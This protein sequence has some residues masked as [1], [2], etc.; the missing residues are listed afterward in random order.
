MHTPF[1]RRPGAA[2]ATR[3]FIA[4]TVIGLLAPAGDAWAQRPPAR[5]VET[6]AV[7]DA[8]RLEAPENIAIDSAGNIFV[9]LVLT[10]EIRRITPDGAQS[11]FATLPIGGP[12]LT[13]CGPFVGGL[14]GLAIDRQDNLYAALAS[15][16]PASRGLWKLTPDGRATQLTTLPMS[17]LPNGV[18]LRQ[19]WLYVADSSLGV[20]WRV[21]ASAPST[22]EVWSDDPLLVPPNTIFPGPN[23]AQFFHDELYVSNPDTQQIIAIPMLPDGSAGAARVHASGLF[24]DDFSFDVHGRLYCGTD[25][26]GTLVRIDCDGSID[27]LLTPADGLDGPTSAIFGRMGNDRRSLY[28]TNAAFP[29][30]STA[31]RPSLMRVDIGVAGMSRL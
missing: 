3:T 18:A 9:T 20:V 29:F 25:P 22:A 8:S 2:I 11:T 19:N 23:G 21:S 1:V 16:D 6:V 12:A 4:A 24:C 5:H 30:F 31:H 13:P 14:T 7:F 28:V 17:G 26:F 10:G 15:C 27:V